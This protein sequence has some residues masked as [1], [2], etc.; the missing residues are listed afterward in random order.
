DLRKKNATYQAEFKRK[1]KSKKDELKSSRSKEKSKKDEL[2]SRSK[3][4]SKK[5]ELKSRSR[6][7]SGSKRSE[8]KSK[9][10][11]KR[12]NEGSRG[13][14]Y[15]QGATDATGEKKET[16]SDAEEKK[17][18]RIRR[19]K[20]ERLDR[21][22]ALYATI[23]EMKRFLAD[24]KLIETKFEFAGRWDDLFRIF[25]RNPYKSALEE[26]TAPGRC[27]PEEEHMMN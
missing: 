20:A 12:D 9:R 8:R 5:D 21:A 18:N 15:T 7:R 13:T 27:Y 10:D 1:E 24:E 22:M 26:N 14:A 19:D 11:S 6:E 23:Q 16:R 4:K 17:A 3:E 2:R 25:K